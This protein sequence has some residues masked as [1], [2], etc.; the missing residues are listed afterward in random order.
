MKTIRIVHSRAEGTLIEGS[1]K[2]DGVFEIVRGH[3]FRSFR[4]LG[5]LG[6]QQSR[7]K[8][9]KRWV[10]D[11]AAEAL[12][13]AGYTV[14]VDIDDVT[15][16]PSF[17]DAEADR[18]A[19]AEDRADRYSSR[20]DTAVAR[21]EGM[22]KQVAEELS[23]IPLGQPHLIGHPSYNRS[24]RAQERR[25]V[26]EGRGHEE[27]RR[28]KY[29][30][31]R[32]QAAEHYQQHRTNPGT[33]LRRLAKLEA[34]RRRLTRTLEDGWEKT[35]SPGA[36]L[37]EGAQVT[38]TYDDGY[39]DCRVRPS[40]DYKARLEA[41]VAQLD[42]EIS[43]WRDVI[44]QA[45]ENGVK[46]W[47]RADFDKGDYV[48]CHET[49][50]EV[51]RAN[52]KSVSIPWSHY[53]VAKGI[54]VWTAAQCQELAHGRMHTDTLPY[55]EVQGKVTRAELEGLNAGQARKLIAAKIREARGEACEEAAGA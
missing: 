16:G 46:V 9:A 26:K 27:V 55:D 6:I 40:G 18:V 4:S 12:R 7:G 5:Q 44:A 34:N 28:G 52:S 20:A 49:A 19:R 45:Q 31:G 47:S 24:V 41:D 3:G 15:L 43:Y 50:V 23:H 53:W 37:P 25:H 42:D 1:T 8:A 29:W 14:D 30:E 10:I 21:G 17:A 33:T 32:A 35:I 22:L 11:A 36:D 51:V 54:P 13:D 39:R 2:G 48:I 38:R